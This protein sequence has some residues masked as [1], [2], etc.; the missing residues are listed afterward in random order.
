MSLLIPKNNI[1]IKIYVWRN[2]YVLLTFV[3][4]AYYISKYNSLHLQT[5]V[6]NIKGTTSVLFCVHISMLSKS[7]SEVSE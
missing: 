2:G 1:H 6:I 7:S 3:N 4:M 5:E